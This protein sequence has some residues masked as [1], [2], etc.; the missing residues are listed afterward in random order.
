MFDDIRRVGEKVDDLLGTDIFPF[1]YPFSY[2]E[3]FLSHMDN[4]EFAI[5]LR[6][7]WFS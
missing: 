4:W 6:F 7:L 3:N 5:P 1:N 2:T